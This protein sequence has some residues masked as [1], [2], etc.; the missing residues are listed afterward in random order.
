VLGCWSGKLQGGSIMTTKKEDHRLALMQEIGCVFDQYVGGRLSYRKAE[1]KLERFF[2]VPTCRVK[3]RDLSAY[4]SRVLE[5]A[6]LGGMGKD[7]AVVNVVTMA[8]SFDG[9]S[10]TA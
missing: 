5:L 2:E 9:V 4:L 3:A 7:E 1:E 10:E 8:L 6:R